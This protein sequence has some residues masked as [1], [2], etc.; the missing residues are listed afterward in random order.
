MYVYSYMFH[1][2]VLFAP[3]ASITNL[4]FLGGFPF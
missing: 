4:T 1:R 3:E 2:I